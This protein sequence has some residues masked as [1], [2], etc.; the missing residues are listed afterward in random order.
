MFWARSQ[1]DKLVPPN[2][3]FTF[4]FLVH[5]SHLNSISILLCKRQTAS[6]KWTQSYCNVGS[7][8]SDN[9]IKFVL[10]KKVT[11]VL[12]KRVKW[13]RGSTVYGENYFPGK[14]ISSQKATTLSFSFL[15]MCLLHSLNILLD[16]EISILFFRKTVYF[17]NLQP[18]YFTSS[19]INCI[20]TVP[21]V[22]FL[23]CRRGKYV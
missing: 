12:C 5:F 16:I 13:R 10:Q 19:G 9:K 11:Y 18:N 8:F 15:I 22:F 7:S 17:G 21:L 6:K 14:L 4:N 2:H 1:S 20:F 23:E 3:S